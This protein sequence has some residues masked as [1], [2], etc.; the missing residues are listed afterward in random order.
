VVVME[1][2]DARE[3]LR[4]VERHRVTACFMVP[5]YFIRLLEVPAAERAT[6]DTSSLRLVLH[7]AAPCPV[8]VKWQILDALPSA[9]IWEFYGATEGGATRI[10]PDAWR[11]HPGSVG[12]PWPGVEILILDAGGRPVGPNETG[13]IF[14]RPP[15]GARFRYH[16]DAGKTDAAWVGDAF[17]VGD[18]GHL[19]ADGYLYVTDRASDMVLRGGVNIYP[20]E[21]EAV[22]QQHPAVVDCAVLGIPDPRLGEE[23]LALV[24]VRGHVGSEELRLFCREHLADFKVPRDIEIVETLPRDPTGKVL[25]RRVRDER[26]AAQAAVSEGQ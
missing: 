12:T 11:T 4:L 1:R 5:A 23:L 16:N 10:S 2:W 22:L 7:A 6:Y 14:I 25:K 15:G 18:V 24:E 9:E 8:P 21:V 3:W 17:S 19:D 26:R 13:T 20:A